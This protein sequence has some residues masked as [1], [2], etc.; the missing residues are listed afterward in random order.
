MKTYEIG[1]YEPLS[2][3]TLWDGKTSLKSRTF[4]NML[5]KEFF[6]NDIETTKN[7]YLLKRKMEVYGNIE[8]REICLAV[9]RDVYKELQEHGHIS[10]D[11]TV[12]HV[13]ENVSQFSTILGTDNYHFGWNLCGLVLKNEYPCAFEMTAFVP[14]VEYMVDFFQKNFHLKPYYNKSLRDIFV[15]I[16]RPRIERDFDVKTW[17]YHFILQ[18]ELRYPN[19]YLYYIQKCF[20]N[21]IKFWED[22][23]IFSSIFKSLCGKLNVAP[24]DIPEVTRNNL[25]YCYH[26][27]K[28]PLPRQLRYTL[29]HFENN[30]LTNFEIQRMLRFEPSHGAC[31]KTVFV[32][33]GHCLHPDS[34]CPF[35]IKNLS[36]SNIMEF[37][38][39]KLY[40]FYVSPSEAFRKC[41]TKEPQ[42]HYLIEKNF[43][44]I[45][46]RELTSTMNN[47]IEA[48]MKLLQT[49]DRYLVENQQGNFIGKNLM[50]IRD[51][52]KSYLNPKF[53]IESE[54]V[55]HGL[56][57]WLAFWNKMD[58]SK[59]KD[60]IHFYF[61]LFFPNV[62]F[63]ENRQIVDV[64][65]PFS[66]EQEENTT[67]VYNY[68][69]NWSLC[70]KL[71]YKKNIHH[72]LQKYGA[73]MENDFLFDNFVEFV[74]V[75]RSVKLLFS[76]SCTDIIQP[77]DNTSKVNF[78]HYFVCYKIMTILQN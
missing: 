11:P 45:L 73:L 76:L 78:K 50:E 4:R 40:M 31:D 8:F 25:L 46:F 18:H 3:F 57:K 26:E 5:R 42:I 6:R 35:Q 14:V 49:E 68:I 15:M 29:Q 77:Y 17:K 63:D 21:Y 67:L 62:K 10:W 12:T 22:E 54:M 65:F 44:N 48:R 60:Y 61:Q 72:I 66:F 51:Q 43:K 33:K 30:R 34:D 38:L 13:F 7:P 64:L 1:Q 20:A 24:V 47:N 9:L 28:L 53:P 71:L 58:G 39:L 36:F 70:E 55:V 52:M 23:K 19:T 32:G 59:E 56:Q 2:T 69:S 41:K 74:S 27:Q 75:I 16:G 37:F